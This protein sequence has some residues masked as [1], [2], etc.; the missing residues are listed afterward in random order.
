MGRLLLGLLLSVLFA[1]RVFAGDITVLAA[2]S[3]TDALNA[4]GDAYHAKTGTTVKFSFAASSALAKQIEA[5][6]PADVFA[7]A[8]EDWMNY[9]ADRKLIDPASRFSPV[10]N[11]LVMIAPS[12]LDRAPFTVSASLDLASLLG[13]D[14]KLAVADPAHVP[15]GIYAKQALTHYKL[16]D[17][18]QSHLAI[19]DDVRGA[20]AFVARGEAPL[21]I[22][23]KTDALISKSV[24]TVATFPPESHDK[25]T[26]PFA[27]VKGAHPEAAKF[28]AYLKSHPARAVFDKYGFTQN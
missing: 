13:K 8:S 18:V 4:I 17:G 10:G 12:S 21:G 24:K 3:L 22:V 5:G 26:Y 1:G 9:L 28:L 27:L 16:W 15:A 20:L 11:A 2:A 23:Y 7:S 14:G 6:A 19:A 25:I